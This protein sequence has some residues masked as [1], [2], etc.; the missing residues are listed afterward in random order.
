MIAQGMS[1]PLTV[2]AYI[3]F[4]LLFV[5]CLILCLMAYWEDKDAGDVSKQD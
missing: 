3:L 5:G 1:K 2:L 4:P